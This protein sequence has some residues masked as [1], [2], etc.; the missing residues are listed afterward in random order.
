MQRKVFK[1]HKDRWGRSRK[2]H[3]CRKVINAGEECVFVQSS[4]WNG[5]SEGFTAHRWCLDKWLERN[6]PITDAALPKVEEIE[7]EFEALRERLAKQ[8]AAKVR[9]AHKAAAA[10]AS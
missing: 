10:K 6:P 2:C 3:F 4:G 9:K 1:N 5:S 8:H 7:R